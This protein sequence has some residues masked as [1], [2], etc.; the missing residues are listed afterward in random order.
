MQNVDSYGPMDLVLFSHDD[1]KQHTMSGS[2]FYR[3]NYLAVHNNVQLSHDAS[4]HQTLL[5]TLRI[6]PVNQ[7]QATHCDMS[8]LSCYYL[9]LDL[10]RASTWVS[11]LTKWC[12]SAT[13]ISHLRSMLSHVISMFCG[14]LLRH[15]KQ[16]IS[17]TLLKLTQWNLH[18][19]DLNQPN[20][21]FS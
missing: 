10:T 19:I 7:Q 1:G 16:N 9:T 18:D 17:T 5:Y 2:I 8:F 15:K 12:S 13:I 14:S 4:S 21:R 3:Q 11:T 20:S 6:G